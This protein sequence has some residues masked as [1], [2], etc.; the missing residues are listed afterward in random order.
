MEFLLA[1]T[2][3]MIAS[4]LLITLEKR[5][6]SAWTPAVATAWISLYQ[7]VASAMKCGASGESLFVAKDGGVTK[8]APGGNSIEAPAK[9]LQST[10]ALLKDKGLEEVGVSV[11]KGTD[12]RFDHSSNRRFA[13]AC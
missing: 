7:D 11:F 1:P 12:M 3:D 6:G 13:K 4:G 2:D 5:L 9:V 8:D 10:W